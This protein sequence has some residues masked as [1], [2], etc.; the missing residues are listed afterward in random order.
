MWWLPKGTAEVIF[1]KLP[2]IASWRSIFARSWLCFF[3]WA[4]FPCGRCAFVGMRMSFGMSSE[5]EFCN[6]IISGESFFLIARTTDDSCIGALDSLLRGSC[7]VTSSSIDVMK[8][9]PDI[10]LNDLAKKQQSH[11][12][13]S[14]DLFKSVISRYSWPTGHRPWPGHDRP[15]GSSW[16]YIAAHD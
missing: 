10:N 1:L 16:L 14:Q 13:E 3:S 8:V 11:H 12:W 4:N 15:R 2:R 6:C 9:E 5:V 7:G